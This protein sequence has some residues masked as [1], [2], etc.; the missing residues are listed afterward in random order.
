VLLI[1]CAGIPGSGKSHIADALRARLTTSRIAYADL[2][3]LLLSEGARDEASIPH[4]GRKLNLGSKEADVL[5][6]SFR[7]FFLEEPDYSLNYLRSVVELE[8]SASVQDLVL[9]S[10][11]YCCAQRGFFLAR[12]DK[13]KAR[14]VLHEEGFVHRLFTLFGYRAGGSRDTRALKQLA[15]SMPLPHTLFWSRCS[16][17]TA[18]DRLSRRVRKTPDRLVGM[19]AQEVERLLVLADQKLETAIGILAKRGTRIAEVPSEEHFEEEALFGGLFAELND[20]DGS[21]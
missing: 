11:T 13:V 17:A 3:E 6:K 19:D 1:E 2:A 20:G 8:P 4:R 14:L 15:E 12:R 7:R 21:R 9:S 16:P 18:I 5:L 10:F